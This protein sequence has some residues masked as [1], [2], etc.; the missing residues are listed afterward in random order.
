M[1]LNSLFIYQPDNLCG[2]SHKRNQICCC[3]WALFLLS[4]TFDCSKRQ[5]LN[6]YFFMYKE[7]FF[8]L[9][10]MNSIHNFFTVLTKF[11]CIIRS[12]NLKLLE[13]HLK[14]CYDSFSFNQH[15]L[16]EMVLNH[17]LKNVQNNLR[18]VKFITF[19]WM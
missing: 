14:L 2:G 13:V 8:A 11:W 3:F 17:F 12:N 18:W 4:C 5:I 15:Y 7:V 16:C 6:K 1:I 19:N 9:Y 10:D